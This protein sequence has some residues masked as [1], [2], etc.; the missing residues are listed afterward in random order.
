MVACPLGGSLSSAD[1]GGLPSSSSAA[2]GGV[3]PETKAMDKGDEES[4]QKPYDV[5]EDVC[6]Q[7]PLPSVDGYGIKLFTTMAEQH[8]LAALLDCAGPVQSHINVE[9]VEASEPLIWMAR[10]SADIPLDTVTLVPW[11]APLVRIVNDAQKNPDG[12]LFESIKR[13]KHH[14]GGLPL[15]AMIQVACPDLQ[16]SL[17]LAARS[18]LSGKQSFNHAPAAFWRALEAAEERVNMEMRFATMEFTNPLLQIDERPKKKRKSVKLQVTF[19]IL[20]NFKPLKEGDALVFS[21]GTKFQIKDDEL[22][23]T[24][25]ICAPDLN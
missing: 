18:P 4:R 2:S 9:F 17:L 25:A 8:L 20:L 19:P 14:V 1:F 5:K 22:K 6:T 7:V 12:V 21:R 24:E 3:P 13:P 10:A 11:A 16:E 15:A 23:Q